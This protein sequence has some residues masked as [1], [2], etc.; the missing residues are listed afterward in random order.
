MKSEEKPIEN[1]T[2]NLEYDIKAEY[3]IIFAVII[4]HLSS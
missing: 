1:T 4:I 2:E 3:I